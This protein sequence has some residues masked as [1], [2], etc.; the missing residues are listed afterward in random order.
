MSIQCLQKKSVYIY[1]IYIH[2]L[3]IYTL[4]ADEVPTIE[5][6][7]RTVANQQS[8]DTRQELFKRIH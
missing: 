6:A 1:N 3:Y 4:T 8:T 5:T 7:L 2:F